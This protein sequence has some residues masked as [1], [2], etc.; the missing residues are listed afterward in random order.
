MMLDACYRAGANTLAAKIAP[1]VQK[2]LLQQKR[3]Y[4]SLDADKQNAL[5]FES[6]NNENLL[7]A[8]H[9]MQQQYTGKRQPQLE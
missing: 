3:Y 2:D 4:Q 8:L 6:N 7:Q 5:Q 9:A 1:A